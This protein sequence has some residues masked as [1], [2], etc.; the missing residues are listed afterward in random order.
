MGKKKLSA[1]IW[2]IVADRFAMESFVGE[3]FVA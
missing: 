3:R 1:K 2:R